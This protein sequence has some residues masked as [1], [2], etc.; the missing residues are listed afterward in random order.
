MSLA[1]QHMPSLGFFNKLLCDSLE[2][3]S[4]ENKDIQFNIPA[5]EKERR[6]VLKEAFNSIKKYNGSYG[7]LNELISHTTNIYPKNKEIIRKNKTI[8]DYTNHLSK[9]DF[10]SHNELTEFQNYIHII[11][12]EKHKNSKISNFS[13]DFYMASINHYRQFIREHSIKQGTEMSAYYYFL[14]YNLSNILVN[15]ATNSTSIDIRAMNIDSEW[16][17]KSFVDYISKIC[18]VSIYRLNIFHEAKRTTP[19]MS[20]K[21]CWKPDLKIEQNTRSKQFIQR[22]TKHNKVKWEQFHNQVKPFICLLPKSMSEDNFI[23]IA[24]YAFVLHNI[25]N[26]INEIIK[27]DLSSKLESNNDITAQDRDV[28]LSETVS[29]KLDKMLN[30]MTLHDKDAIDQATVDYENFVDK[31]RYLNSS[32]LNGS[33]FPSSLDFIYKE[34]YFNIEQL[35]KSLT[36]IP[37]WISLWR[38]ARDQ[39]LNDNPIEALS[40][41]KN[42][43]EKAKYVAGSLFLPF[44]IDACSFCK[45]QYNL[46]K[47]N[48]EEDLFDRFYGSFGGDISKYA[49]LLGYSPAYIR[50]EKTLLPW[51]EL[52]IKSKLLIQK[53]SFAGSSDIS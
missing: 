13:S 44:Y 4:S 20:D 33:N 30:Q 22:L 34:H 18:D 36:D 48:N 1:K 52:P 17:L 46:M 25:N 2:L 11:I 26:H 8:Q 31:L 16:P 27:Y 10:L 3:W 12:C 28:F 29:D 50:D 14:K 5:S 39:N 42:A 41:Y 53:I 47:K 6:E 35:H 15:M 32:Y 45:K 40:Y 23:I 24:F 19:I 51:S 38:L 7:G 43:L 49:S 21:D 37:E 9:D